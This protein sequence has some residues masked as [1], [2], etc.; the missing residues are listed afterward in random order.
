MATKVN[1]ITPWHQNPSSSKIFV[2]LHSEEVNEI[3]SRPPNWL[4]GWGLSIFFSIMVVLI[5]ACCLIKY[6][7][8]LAV[9]FTLTAMDAPRVI[10]VKTDGKLTRLLVK[11]NQ[12]VSKGQ[13]LTYSESTGDHGQ[14]I[15]LGE[16]LDKFA[17]AVKANR[18]S[19]VNDLNIAS[20]NRLGEIQNDYQVFTQK[21]DELKAF[22]SGGYFLKRRILLLKDVQDLHELESNLRE[23][24]KLQ[25]RD[26]ELAE[27][28]FMVHEKLY[29]SKA[30]APLEFKREK[31]KLL[32]REIPIRNLMSTL[33]Q[34]RS[35]QTGKQKEILELDNT[36]LE[37]KR[38]FQ[39]ELQTLQANIEMWKQR[40][41]LTA[42]VSGK[43][44]FTAPWQDQQYLTAG[45]ELFTVEPE[46]NIYRGLVKFPQT[47]FGKVREGQTVL[48]KLDGFPYREFGLL[49]GKLSRISMTPGKDSTFWGYVTLPRNLTT[50]FGHILAY[51]SGLKGQAEILTKD[52][53]IA[54]RLLSVNLTQ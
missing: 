49:E 32:A 4:V 31:A 23:Q 42:P 5:A 36:I 19:S 13:L 33:V 3:M 24:L 21:L 1:T 44:S 43:L 48:I 6:P 46:S 52:R 16:D 37:R 35:S 22:L 18:W 27:D 12:I 17:N 25:N 29:A 30:I 10:V 8:V 50:K 54:E 45:Q 34:N 28:E 20:Y 7:D 47:N 40:Y 41:V 14:I 11:D 39:Q 15:R 38:L 9:P 26:Y 2:E 53:T 51:R